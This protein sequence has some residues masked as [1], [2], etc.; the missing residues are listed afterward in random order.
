MKRTNLFLWSVVFALLAA[1]AWGA[2]N[3]GSLP[4]PLTL[5]YALS[6]VDEA[7]PELEHY[8]ARIEAAEAQ[9][10]IAQALT[11]TKVA[12]EARLQAIAPSHRSLSQDNN[13][14]SLKL[15]LHKQLYDFGR[16]RFALSA[17]DQEMQGR[18]WDYLNARQQRYLAIMASYFNVLLA[19][20]EY[21][22]DNEVMTMAFLHWDKLKER[23]ALGQVSDIELLEKESLF[24]SAR[25]NRQL[26]ENLQ[27]ASRSR[28]ANNLNRPGQL[29]SDLEI[30]KLMGL[31]RKP[32]ALEPLTQLVLQ[33]NPALNAL[34]AK[35]RAADEE[36]RSAKAGDSPVIHGEL[37]AAAYNRVS[38]SRHPLTASLVM[39][40][41]FST[42]GAVDAT[43]ARL[44]ALV[45]QQR[46]AL[47]KAEFEMRQAVL[48][49]W[50]EINALKAEVREVAAVGAYRELY[51]D[52]SR[53]LYE[54]EVQS[55][56][57]DAQS[58]I[59]DYHLRKAEVEYRLTLAWVRLDALSGRLVDAIDSGE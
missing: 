2:D 16:T 50:L 18:E 39:E 9:Q 32:Q 37:E 38:G 3:T 35:L 54:Q 43:V 24:Q 27:R 23:G 40:I 33:E 49:L 6:L 17:A 34:R 7:H 46:A 29:S 48:E 41:P 22:R 5:N 57:G 28:L 8:R 13:D 59:S 11:G 55:D 42:G 47:R 36:V 15:K 45:H 56:L 20:L 30:P 31:N 10:Q 4:E 51:L 53:A 12:L 58:Q 26:S 25:S 1:S 52:R 44:R 21:I 14:S 19:D